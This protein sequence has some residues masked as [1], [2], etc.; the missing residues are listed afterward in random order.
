MD[1]A[2]WKS[3]RRVCD[4]EEEHMPLDHVDIAPI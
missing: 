1:T 4:G 3:H 2:Q